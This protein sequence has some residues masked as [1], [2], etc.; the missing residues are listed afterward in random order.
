MGKVIHV[1][2]DVNSSHLW[3]QFYVYSAVMK[4]GLRRS[5]LYSLALVVSDLCCYKVSQLVEGFDHAESI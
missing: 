2:D 1:L 4:D 5:L 3:L